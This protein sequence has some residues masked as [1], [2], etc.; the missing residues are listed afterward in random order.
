MEI[1]FIVAALSVVS[2][3]VLW[4]GARRAA[5]SRL[6]DSASARIAIYRDQLAEIDADLAR[7]TIDAGDAASHRT[8]VARRL[9]AASASQDVAQ[10]VGRR[11][12]MPVPALLVPLFALAIY[13][14]VGAPGMPDLPQAERLAQAEKSNDLE[15][16]VY[17]VERHLA[18]HPDDVTGW[19]VVLPSYQAMGR[20]GDAAQAYRRLIVLKGP[21]AELYANL[22]EMLMFSGNGL[23]PAEGAAAA[24]EALKLDPKHSKARYYEALGLVQDGKAAEAL[25]RFETLLAEAPP[26]APW[27]D[28]VVK[29]IAELKVAGTKPSGPSQEQ[30]DAA[31][32]MSAAD[33]QE[34]IR[35]MV[36][37]LAAKLEADPKNLEGWLRLIRARVVLKEAD[38]AKA[39]LQKARSTFDG[40]QGALGELA[41]LAA[42]LELK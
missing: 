11:W 28:A 27:R 34:M 5:G 1:W 22:A 42:E 8:E 24:R 23:M 14:R 29:Q 32:S 35:S 17:K 3:A 25:A 31:G 26:D 30:V 16:L 21:S 38:I 10:N 39:A 37:G 41:A 18:Q 20:F 6:E 15:A 13:A 33:Q 7:G 40:D 2:V 4:F 12:F 19:D 36:D 9:L